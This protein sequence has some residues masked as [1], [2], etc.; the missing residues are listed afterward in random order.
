[1]NGANLRRAPGPR[2]PRYEATE[3]AHVQRAGNRRI[4]THFSRCKTGERTGASARYSRFLGVA[5]SRETMGLLES[6]EQHLSCGANCPIWD[7]TSQPC[8]T[9]SFQGFS[10]A[11]ERREPDAFAGTEGAR[12]RRF[13]PITPM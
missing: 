3:G 12:I 13:L 5:P 8:H 7:N 6:P 2:E 9:V 1:M 10:D 4:S 11:I